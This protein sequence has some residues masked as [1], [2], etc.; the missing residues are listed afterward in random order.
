MEDMDMDMD[1][2]NFSEG[3]PWQQFKDTIV[4]VNKIQGYNCLGKPNYNVTISR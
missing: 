4:K 3:R 1:M 2:D